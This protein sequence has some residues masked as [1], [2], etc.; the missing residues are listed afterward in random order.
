MKAMLRIPLVI[1]LSC[2]I[3]AQLAAQHGAP[4]PDYETYEGSESG[5]K[6]YLPEPWAAVEEEGIVTIASRAS[7]FEQDRRRPADGDSILVVYPVSD[8]V[9]R[10]LAADQS[11]L[12]EL[13][14]E[15]FS[16]ATSAVREESDRP[17]EPRPFERIEGSGT[18]VGRI[19]FELPREDGDRATAH[20]MAAVLV[21]NADDAPVLVGVGFTAAD[22]AVSAIATLTSIMS[23]V[24]PL[25]EVDP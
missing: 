4:R 7:F 8:L 10:S 17:L 2:L 9:R 21:T 22:D 3:A 5:M 1:A 14:E 16:V 23:S 12:L 13:T 6:L 25:D 24:A 20:R 18:P 15:L 11:D 19:V